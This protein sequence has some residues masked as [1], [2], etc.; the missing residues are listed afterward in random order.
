MSR[1]FRPRPWEL[2]DDWPDVNSADPIGEVARQFVLNLRTAIGDR[3]IRA[4]AKDAGINHVTLL[5]VLEGRSWPDLAT[6]AKLERGLGVDL[7]P[8][9]VGNGG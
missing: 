6:I 1:P 3:S 9:R 5:I 2:A 4:I 8:G 7:W